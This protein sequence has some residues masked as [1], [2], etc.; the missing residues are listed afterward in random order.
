M[1]RANAS[2]RFWRR[3]STKSKS[4]RS[5]RPPRPDL[6]ASLVTGP[7]LLEGPFHV[8]PGHLLAPRQIEIGVVHRLRRAGGGVGGNSDRL[9]GAG[10]S[11]EGGRRLARSF[12]IE[13]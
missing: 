13:S 8:Y 5:R 10:V 7:Q 1:R 12:R 3:Q 2:P 4:S 9:G 6:V 11:P